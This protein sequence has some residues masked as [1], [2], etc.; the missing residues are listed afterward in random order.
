MKGMGISV[1]NDEKRQELIYLGIS[2]SDTLWEVKRNK[3]KRFKAL[4]IK[5]MEIIESASNVK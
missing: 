1:V 4:S 5:Q 3:S 2:G